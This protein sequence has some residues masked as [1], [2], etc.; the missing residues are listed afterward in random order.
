MV[1]ALPTRLA[2]ITEGDP[3]LPV[4]LRTRRAAVLTASLARR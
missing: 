4:Y 3:A 2:K 1:T